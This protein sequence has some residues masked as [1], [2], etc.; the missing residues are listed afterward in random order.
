MADGLRI[1]QNEALVCQYPLD[2]SSRDRYA[3]YR[4]LTGYLV[5][6]ISHGHQTRCLRSS[7]LPNGQRHASACL[8]PFPELAKPL[9]EDD[10]E[11]IPRHR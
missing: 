10:A 9:N 5:Q 1:V 11:D 6:E 4:H 7:L 3:S 2:L 8:R